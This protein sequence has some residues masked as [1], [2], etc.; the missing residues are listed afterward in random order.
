MELIEINDTN[1]VSVEVEICSSSLLLH[2][3][4]VL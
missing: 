3:S 1:V 2:L 4:T